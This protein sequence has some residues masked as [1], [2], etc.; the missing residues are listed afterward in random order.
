MHAKR[1]KTMSQLSNLQGVKYIEVD[2][3]SH[4][5]RLSTKGKSRKNDKNYDPS[6][7]G[8]QDLEKKI[9]MIST[10]RVVNL[11]CNKPKLQLID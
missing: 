1:V 11:H 4:D 8:F 2:I 5:V 7:L 9:R 6:T 10:I 3:T